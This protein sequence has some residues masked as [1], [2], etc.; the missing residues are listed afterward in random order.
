MEV[1]VRVYFAVLYHSAL[2]TIKEKRQGVRY[3][4][5]D[6]TSLAAELKNPKTANMIALGSL[7]EVLK[8]VSISALHESLKYKFGDK[9]PELIQLNEKAIEAGIK[10]VNG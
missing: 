10:A 2:V 6:Y 3:I 1:Y 7:N 9:K 4:G 8:C 5:I